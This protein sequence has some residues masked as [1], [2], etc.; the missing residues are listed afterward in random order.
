MGFDAFGPRASR[1]LAAA[2]G[3]TLAAATHAADNQPQVMKKVTI[4][5]EAETYAAES[6]SSSK[7]T[8]PLLDT[9]QT[10]TVIPAT[11]IRERAATTL[12]DVLRNSPGI[13]FQAGEG[14]AGLG[15]AAG[16]RAV[17]RHGQCEALLEVRDGS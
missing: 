7:Y 1:I 3:A 9:P 8:Q 4:G 15:D 6:S 10:I 5:A 14:G 17:A 11:V 13:T 2:V 12:R 16:G